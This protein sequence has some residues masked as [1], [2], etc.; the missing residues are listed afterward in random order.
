MHVTRTSSK[1]FGILRQ[2]RTVKR[3]VPADTFQ[4]LVVSLVLS[5]SD[6]GNA[7]LASLPASLLSQLQP[8]MYTGALVIFNANRREHVTPL[9]RQLHWLRVPERITF[10]L[11]TL[12]FQC[13]NGTAPG[14]LSAD[15]R[16]VADVPGR[17]NLRS[18]ASSS[19]AIPA[20]RRMST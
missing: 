11:A 5:R 2:L 8:V 13:I 14:Y 3:S 19:L 18:A 4:G 10:K 1:C 7:T 6:Y 12:M 20:T 9:L 16:Q 15:V 17:K